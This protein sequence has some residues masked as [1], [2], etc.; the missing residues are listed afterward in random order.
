MPA[1]QNSRL[2]GA[3]AA[4]ALCLSA[5]AS[6]TPAPPVAEWDL[7]QPTLQNGAVNALFQNAIDSRT[8]A[9]IVSIGYQSEAVFHTSALGAQAPDG[10]TPMSLSTI[11]RAYSM[12]KPVTAVAMMI[13]YEEGRWSPSDPI[14]RF[15]PEFENLQVYRGADA[16]GRPVLSPPARAATM[17]ELL[18]H[19]AGF[20]YGFFGDSY[21]DTQYRAANLFQSE[22]ADDFIQRVAQLP[23]AYEPGTEWRYSISMDIE[24]AIIERIT[25]QTLGAFMQQRIFGPLGM[26][27]TRFYLR[28]EDQ[29]RMAAMTQV[30]NGALVAA[31][32]PPPPSSP[33]GF[34]M[35]GAG[36]LTTAIDYSRFARMLLRDGELDGVRILRPSSVRM[37]MSSHLPTRL[38]DGTW[39]QGLHR[40]IPGY[41][42]GFN[43]AVVTDPEASSTPVGRGTYLWDG[44][45]G[46]FFWVDPENDI[47]F[48]A[49]MQRFDS[50]LQRGA[51]SVVHQ[52]YID[53]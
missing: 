49:M 30:E 48:V 9:G 15:I 35:G 25:G 8:Q 20:T 46:T 21:A 10:E 28:A 4:L 7:T 53:R 31:P 33:P 5:C 45:G 32:T 42:Y 38:V 26:N 12:T 27:D 1:N 17:E 52:F 14:T 44:A 39:G 23:L 40:M 34:E 29:A 37:M 16:E 11:F 50:A 24:G 36:L 41:E 22:S 2:R 18:T 19:T 43:G 6:S 13:L 47:V 3:V 51:Q